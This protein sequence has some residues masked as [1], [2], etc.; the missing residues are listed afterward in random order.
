MHATHDLRARLGTV[1]RPARLGH[2]TSHVA[3]VMCSGSTAASPVD[4]APGAT[5]ST[6]VGPLVGSATAVA[7]Q[8]WRATSAARRRAAS[9]ANT[10]GCTHA[11]WLPFRLTRR[12]SRPLLQRRPAPARTVSRPPGRLRSGQRT[13]PARFEATAARKVNNVAR[14]GHQFILCAAV[15]LSQSRVRATFKGSIEGGGLKRMS[16]FRGL[17]PHTRS[18]QSLGVSLSARACAFTLV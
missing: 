9:M 5:P 8:T 10:R 3:S 18:Y 14:L 2:R 13:A 15:S 1:A 4:T 11:F 17:E 7:P 16:V 12:G 6:P